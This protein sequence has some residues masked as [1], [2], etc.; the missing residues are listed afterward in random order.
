MT[1]TLIA[2]STS[3]QR[4]ADHAIIPDDPKNAD[5]QVYQAWIGAGN[6]PNPAPAVA[7]SPP[8]SVQIVS[9]STPALNGTYGIQPSDIQNLNSE[10]IFVNAT[11][12]QGSAKFTNGDTSLPW[13][14]VSGTP[15]VF[16]VAQFIA[17][18]EA[19]A[20]YQSGVEYAVLQGSTTYPSQPVTIP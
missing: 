5:W 8:V 1:Y 7:P 13:F 3:V 11:M 18:A 17:L 6:T 15:H 10:M 14:D 2:N 16:T 19:L 12:A 4:D 9:T 20:E